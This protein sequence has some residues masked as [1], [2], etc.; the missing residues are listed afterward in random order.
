MDTR[1]EYSYLC[2]FFGFL[3]E[4]ETYGEVQ[5]NEQLIN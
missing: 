5:M 1:I 4:R 2:G 3:S